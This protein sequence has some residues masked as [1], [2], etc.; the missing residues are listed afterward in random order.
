MLESEPKLIFKAMFFMYEL[1]I[2]YFFIFIYFSFSW[3][4][5]SLY[6]LSKIK[7]LM[8]TSFNFLVTTLNMSDLFASIL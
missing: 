5:N 1:M 2:I 4:A 8:F 7:Q 3:L 6:K